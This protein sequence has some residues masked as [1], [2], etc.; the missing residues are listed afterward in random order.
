MR[1]EDTKTPCW[2][3]PLPPPAFWEVPG[4]QAQRRISLWSSDI[5]GCWANAKESQSVQGKGRVTECLKGKNI[6][7]ECSLKRTI[8]LPMTLHCSCVIS[9]ALPAPSWSRV[10][11]N[12]P[13]EW[14]KCGLPGKGHQRLLKRENLRSGQLTNGISGW[15]DGVWIAES[16]QECG[17][18]PIKIS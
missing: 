17:R 3:R 13:L 6:P 2:L 9:V 16:P 18:I 10:L 7:Q 11:S 14:E 1:L 12:S 4:P 5:F 15:T 8:L